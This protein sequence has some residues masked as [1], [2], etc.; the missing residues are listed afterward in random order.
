M[1]IATCKWQRER[2]RWWYES[3]IKKFEILK[4]GGGQ[5]NVYT[6]VKQQYG[7][8][9]VC[10]NYSTS[11]DNNYFHRKGAPDIFSTHMCTCTV[12]V[13]VIKKIVDDCSDKIPLVTPCE[14]TVYFFV[15]SF[16]VHVA[17]R[18]NFFVIFWNG[19]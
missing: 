1:R 3:E 18:I 6:M 17:N 11:M 13:P 5:C 8:F 19:K 12:Q 10:V 9:N 4:V 15:S 16:C 7:Y 14:C 2:W